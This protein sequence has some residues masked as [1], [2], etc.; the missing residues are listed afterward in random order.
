MREDIAPRVARAAAAWREYDR[1]IK[2]VDR[3]AAQNPVDL[4]EH[5][6][7]YAIDRC[8]EHRLK[9]Y[10]RF[11]VR[12]SLD[13]NAM[14]AHPERLFTT[15][16]GCRTFMDEVFGF[17][18]WGNAWLAIDIAKGAAMDEVQDLSS[19]SSVRIG[20]FLDVLRSA[21]CF[22]GNGMMPENHPYFGEGAAIG[23]EMAT[24]LAGWIRSKTRLYPGLKEAL[25]VEEGR[26]P[27]D[28]LLHE[29]PG[30][31]IAEWNEAQDVKGL[32]ALRNRVSR[33]LTKAGTEEKARDGLPTDRAS[34]V[35]ASSEDAA[36]LERFEQHEY[37]RALATSARLS[38]RERE[39]FDLLLGGFCSK[40]VAK[41][42]NITEGTVKTTKSRALDKLTKAS[43]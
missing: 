34:E 23:D 30:V 29:L 32:F 3:C 27:S 8:E 15:V 9:L 22:F 17:V 26:K 19:A 16:E 36:E 12:A 31:T 20:A 7:E 6:R 24:V 1:V 37:L 25:T 10:K 21:P 33:V 43:A 42:M 5:L 2:D 40:D 38:P 11:G 4:L 14:V 13:G 39:L 28:R 41:K 18:L 35:V